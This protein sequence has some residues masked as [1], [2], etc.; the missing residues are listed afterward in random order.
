MAFP[1]LTCQWECVTRWLHH[2]SSVCSYTV[3]M[4]ILNESDTDS[5]MRAEQKWAF[6][7]KQRITIKDYQAFLMIHNIFQ[8]ESADDLF[9][10]CSWALN[11]SSLQRGTCMAAERGVG[12]RVAWTT[13]F[14]EPSHVILEWLYSCWLSVR[15]CD[16]RKEARWRISPLLSGQ[17]APLFSCLRQSWVNYI[18]SCEIDKHP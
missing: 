18:S 15:C 3:W 2:R 14:E 9:P 13:P 4:S 6:T 10:F 17:S 5:P 16:W 1:Y 7:E 11:N 8:T 12:G